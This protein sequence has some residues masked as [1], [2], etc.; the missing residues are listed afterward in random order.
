MF[1]RK[2][3]NPRVCVVNGGKLLTS[4]S[5]DWLLLDC[6]LLA[7][8]VRACVCVCLLHYAYDDL[9]GYYR[10]PCLRKSLTKKR[11]NRQ[12]VPI[13]SCCCYSS[14]LRK[15]PLCVCVRNVYHFIFYYWIMD[16]RID[17]ALRRWLLMVVLLLMHGWHVI[18]LCL[19]F[20]DCL[21]C[22]V[23]HLCSILWTGTLG[24]LW[25]LNLI[26]CDAIR[27]FIA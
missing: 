27:W 16:T 26:C 7:P 19:L 21:L 5:I 12:R 4:L 13:G 11:Q 25:K 14:V 15:C 22:F 24:I 20:E 9:F 23:V 17:L 6:V 1:E 8:C 10:C 2:Q 18:S 3:N